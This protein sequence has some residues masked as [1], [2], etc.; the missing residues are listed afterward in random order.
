MLTPSYGH[1]SDWYAVEVD[2]KCVAVPFFSMMAQEQ[3]NVF[4]PD[5]RAW[6]QS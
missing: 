4:P 6:R 2:S 5:R 3:R 1:L